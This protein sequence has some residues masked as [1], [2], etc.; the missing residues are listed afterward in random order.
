MSFSHESASV[1]SSSWASPYGFSSFQNSPS[2][3]RPFP[4]GQGYSQFGYPQVNPYGV[5]PPAWQC[6]PPNIL[7][8]VVLLRHLVFLGSRLLSFPVLTLS[9]AM[10]PLSLPFRLCLPHLCLFVVHRRLTMC[11]CHLFL[12]S[13]VPSGNMS[14]PPDEDILSLCP[15]VRDGRIPFFRRQY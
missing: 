12:S 5:I 8:G 10:L 15:G 9:R 1:V 3:S 4:F 13:H 7:F 11:L 2:G 14:V 6:P